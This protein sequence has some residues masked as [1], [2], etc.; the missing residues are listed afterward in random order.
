MNSD[1]HYL[2]SKINS[3]EHPKWPNNE[4][5]IIWI[6]INLKNKNLIN[7][8]VY[9]PIELLKIKM[10]YIKKYMHCTKEIVYIEEILEKYEQEKITSLKDLSILIKKI[11]DLTECIDNLYTKALKNNDITY[12]HNNLDEYIEI[13][14]LEKTNK[15]PI[16]KNN[17]DINDDKIEIIND[18]EKTL[19]FYKQNK[20]DV[21]DKDI[22]ILKDLEKTMSFDKINSKEE[23]EILDY[24]DKT[25][26]IPKLSKNQLKKLD[27][28][29]ETI[30]VLDFLEKTRKFPKIKEIELTKE[31]FAKLKALEKT[32]KINRYQITESILNEI[33]NRK[34]KRK[35]IFVSVLVVL[36]FIFFASSY[37]IISWYKNNL[38][39]KQEIE[40]ITS[41]IE[42]KEFDEENNLVQNNDDIYLNDTFIDVDFNELKKTND[43]TIGWIYV[44]GTNIDY[45]FVQTKDND[46][47]LNH[48]FTKNYNEAGWVF[49]DYRNN[50]NDLDLNTIIYAHGRLDK[51][52]F[53]S[54]RNTLEETWYSDNNNHYI[55]VSMLE[56][57]TLWQVFSVYKIKTETYYLKNN[58]TSYDT[59]NEFIK[60]LQERSIYDFNINVTTDDKILTLS[61]CFDNFQKVVVHAKMIKQYKK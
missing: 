13:L 57:N 8:L 47:Y 10:Q 21:N 30:E 40:N 61:T 48:S 36:C 58:F 31:E 33:S 60:T 34:K 15:M 1:L 51:T 17:V 27:V 54:L 29:D 45:P 22:E 25:I 32:I 26:Q 12:F 7:Q 43:E 11:E 52:M 42:V 49:M 28:N 56:N 24:L 35:I 20:I 2:L 55:K 50:P 6:I 59:H 23:V 41:N 19:K 9:K 37:R 16:I 4:E 53:G 46:F 18:L 14:D 5:A 38:D 44:P 39:L 3:I